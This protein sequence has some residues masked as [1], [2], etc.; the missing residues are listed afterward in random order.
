MLLSTSLSVLTSVTWADICRAAG[1][2]EYPALGG[3]SA[4]TRV[5]SGARNYHLHTVC[6]RRW[7]RHKGDLTNTINEHGQ[8]PLYPWREGRSPS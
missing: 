8:N 2:P 7:G 1:A 5:N 3:Q 6:Q 4:I